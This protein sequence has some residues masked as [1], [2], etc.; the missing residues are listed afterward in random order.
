[1]GNSR[2]ASWT[3]RHLGLATGGA[4]A[5]LL[6]LLESDEA[7]AKNK[8]RRKRKR[9]QKRRQRRRRR[10]QNQNPN[11]PPTDH[12]DIILIN[13]DDMRED[14]YLALT[15]TRALLA[16]Q[17]ATYPNFFLT[18]PLCAPSRATL[19]RGQYAHNT[20][21][22]ANTGNNGG[23]TAFNRINED[24]IATWLRDADPSYR[25]AHVGKHING[26]R[27]AQ[28][29]IGPGW[30]DWIVPVPVAF[31]NYTLNVNGESEEYGDGPRHYLTDI[32]A[33]K[34][35]GI[36]ATTP[37]E[38][39][40]FLY[41]APKAPHGPSIPANRHEGDFAGA[42]LG[43]DKPSFNEED[44]SDKPAY[45]QRDPLSQAD[46][47]ALERSNQLRLESLL[48]VDEA[49]ESLIDALEQAGRLEQTYIFFV[50]DN[51][52]L[53]G[54]HRRTAKNVPYEEVI[55]MSMLLRGPGVRRGV[56]DAMVAN[57]DLA[58][59][60]AEL[61]GVAPPGFVDGR[62]L[63]PTF[64]GAGNSRQAILLEMFPPSAQTD[65]EEAAAEFPAERQLLA[66]QAEALSVR[67]AIRTGDW[68]YVEHGT[69]E[70]EL[71]DL[72]DDPFELDSLHEDPAL[73]ERSQELSAWLAALRDCS[74][75][76]CRDAENGPPG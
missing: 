41:F 56:N 63:V 3:R 60:I 45:M 10:D 59:T 57:I 32:M 36:I 66:E 71:Y 30:T 54:E 38:T 31:Y 76:S 2:F 64:G 52:Y 27:A 48:A 72:R 69:G 47:N 58:P 34:A 42:V 11:P 17:G 61:A 73:S 74:A 49:I 67:R 28:G 1:M 68:V 20:N 53:L 44:M 46:I 7:D 25:T 50:T 13:V 40:L 43:T 55:R 8:N 14:D 24:T 29:Q 35:R 39:P 33:E 51:G 19:L 23:W 65:P 5:S 12:P 15:R 16:G 62:S 4:L 9:R 70:G 75:A 6:E 26:Y 37:A 18:T 22:R 21:V